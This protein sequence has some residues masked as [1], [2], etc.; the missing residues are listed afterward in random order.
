LPLDLLLLA[1]HQFLQRSGQVEM[2]KAPVE[3]AEG[4]WR[5]YSGRVH[6]GEVEV[7][8]CPVA[9]LLVACVLHLLPHL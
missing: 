7:G 6:G 1:R 5:I 3:L 4:L 2:S 8:N 9:F